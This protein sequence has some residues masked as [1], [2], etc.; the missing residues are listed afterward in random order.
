MDELG[1]D[2]LLIND[3]WTIGYPNEN[4]N[5]DPLSHTIHGIQ[6]QVD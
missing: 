6:F 1:K 2:K 5:L 3:A 4:M